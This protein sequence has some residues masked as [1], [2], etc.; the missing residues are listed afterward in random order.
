MR[1]MPLEDT[2]KVDAISTDPAGPVNLTIFDAWDWS[3]ERA[4]LV[5]LQAKFNVYFG[6]IQSGQLVENYP[7][8]KELPLVIR[9]ITKFPLSQAGEKLIEQAGIA[10][11]QLSIKVHSFVLPT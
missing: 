6:F 5:A 3:D 9:V 2:T 1:G 10:A 7:K 11:A 8:A 4:H